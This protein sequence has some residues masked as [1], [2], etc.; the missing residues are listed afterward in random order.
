MTHRW[1]V[2]IPLPPPLRV[3]EKPQDI[4][5]RIEVAVEVPERIATLRAVL[6]AVTAAHEVTAED[7]LGPSR[8][9]E[10]VEARK[11]CMRQLDAMGWAPARIGKALNRDRATVL[12]GL[13]RRK[14]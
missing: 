8:K 14:R 1:D 7:I 13:G 6:D 3:V 2:P 11:E 9:S 5:R 10:H 4:P 12:A